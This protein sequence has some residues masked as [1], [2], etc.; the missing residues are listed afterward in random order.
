[1]GTHQEAQSEERSAAAAAAEKGGAARRRLG[2]GSRLLPG[3]HPLHNIKFPFEQI[4]RDYPVNDPFFTRAYFPDLVMERVEVRLG[5]WAAFSSGSGSERRLFG[6]E[7][8]CVRSTRSF[9]YPG[10]RRCEW[11]MSLE[12]R[13]LQL[14]PSG[15]PWTVVSGLA[16]G[17]SVGL[18]VCVGPA[19]RGSEGAV[20]GANREACEGVSLGACDRIT[21]GASEGQSLARL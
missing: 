14:P 10:R 11:S 5:V 7:R 12:P 17:V 1:M 6:A 13:M 21:L 3:S 4:V 16:R 8:G 9:T 2:G 20:D 19:L 18:C 15:C